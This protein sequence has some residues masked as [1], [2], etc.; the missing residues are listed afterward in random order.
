MALLARR[1]KILGMDRGEGVRCL[2]YGVSGMAIGTTGDLFRITES[3]VFPVIAVHVGPGRHIE[4]IVSLHHLFIAV[5]F[6][7]DL[8]MEHP[9]GLKFRIIHRFDIVEIVAI[10]TGGRILIACGYRFPVNRLPVHRLLVMTPDALGNDNAFVVFPVAV[11]VDVGMAVG[12]PDIFLYM[13]AGIML[14]IF[15]FMAALA[16]D[17]FHFYLTLHMPGKVGKLD[18]T[19]VAAI[20]AVNGRDKGSG[21]DFIP[22]AAEAGSRIDRQTLIRLQ[23]ISGQKKHHDRERQTGKPVEHAVPPI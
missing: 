13:Y 1:D 11:R 6:Q 9:V 17:P 20:L 23:W 7:T 4:D 8:G 12:A 14:G 5:A 10:V 21:G 22:V 16:A 18:M 19:A 3:K 15:F 2:H